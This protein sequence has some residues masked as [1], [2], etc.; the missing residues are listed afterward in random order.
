MEGLIREREKHI[1][2]LKAEKHFKSAD[3]TTVR[4]FLP[5]YEKIIKM[6]SWDDVDDKVL[7]HNFSNQDSEVDLEGKQ[8]SLLR[9]SRSNIIIV[10]IRRR[11]LMAIKSSYFRQVFSNM[12]KCFHLL[13]SSMKK[14]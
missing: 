5:C 7:N 9:S 14:D 1:L 3:W 13:L 2:Q 10:E 4:K 12:Q 11:L 6:K 8:N